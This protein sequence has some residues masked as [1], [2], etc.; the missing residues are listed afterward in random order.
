MAMLQPLTKPQVQE[1]TARLEARLVRTK[2]RLYSAHRAVQALDREVR[3]L[4]GMIS[5]LDAVI[6]ALD[7]LERDEA[8]LGDLSPRSEVDEETVLIEEEPPVG[9]D[10]RESIAPG[11]E[12]YYRQPGAADR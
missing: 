6:N 11:D 3:Q 5:H 4:D 9:D 8:A 7:M 2:D 1:L 12:H 10:D